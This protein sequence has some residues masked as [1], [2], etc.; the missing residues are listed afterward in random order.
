MNGRSEPHT[1]GMNRRAA[2]ADVTALTVAFA[3]L[4]AAIVAGRWGWTGLLLY[5]AVGGPL[6][7]WW[8]RGRLEDYRR[9]PEDAPREHRNNVRNP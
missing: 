8:L 9:L 1:N 7:G 2:H 3:L 4:A 6:V 5:A